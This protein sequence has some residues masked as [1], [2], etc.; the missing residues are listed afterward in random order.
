V[1]S[2]SGITDQD[3]YNLACLYSR[4][5][6]ATKKAQSVSDEQRKRTVDAHISHAMQW[7]KSAVAAGWFLD[8][9]RREMAKK[10]PDLDILRDCPEFE[11]I[12]LDAQ[13][14]AYPFAPRP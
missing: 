10:D 14:P 13:F 12:L 8:P 7:L 4:D 2:A 6:A 9:A 11:D 1:R 5:A 3:C